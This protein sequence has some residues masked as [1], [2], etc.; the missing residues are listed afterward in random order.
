LLQ[1][2]WRPPGHKRC[3]AARELRVQTDCK[4]NLISLGMSAIVIPFDHLVGNVAV[5]FSVIL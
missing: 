3:R 2:T 4:I 1:C 5:F